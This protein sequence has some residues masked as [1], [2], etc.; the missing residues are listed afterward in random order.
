MASDGDPGAE[1]A[2]GAHVPPW[3]GG[4]DSVWAGGPLPAPLTDTLQ[5]GFRAKRIC[6]SVLPEVQGCPGWWAPARAAPTPPLDVPPTPS[7]LPE[8]GLPEDISA[9]SRGVP[10]LPRLTWALGQEPCPPSPLRAGSRP[11]PLKPGGL[12]PRTA[13]DIREPCLGLVGR[14]QGSGRPAPR[15]GQACPSC[16]FLGALPLG[17]LCL[18]L[19]SLIRWPLP[20]RAFWGERKGLGGGEGWWR[21]TGAWSRGLAPP[22]ASRRL[23]DLPGFPPCPSGSSAGRKAPLLDRTLSLG[24]HPS[25]IVPA[26]SNRPGCGPDPGPRAALQAPPPHPWR[27]WPGWSHPTPL[28]LL[29][30]VCY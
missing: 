22:R 5:P 18:S 20:P 4:L 30:W 29:P 9:P 7:S 14:G 16:P 12:H 6:S 8:L 21:E 24:S 10:T 13:Q 3:E 15:G 23:R 11:H 26:S 25:P 2:A 17:R 1:A 27:S 19:H 28:L